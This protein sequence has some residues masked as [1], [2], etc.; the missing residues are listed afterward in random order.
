LEVA[1]SVRLSFPRWGALYLLCLSNLW[2]RVHSP[3]IKMPFD[4]LPRSFVSLSIIIGGVNR[5]A[6]LVIPLAQGRHGVS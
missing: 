1:L 4:L 2:D 6:Q 3:D 5:Y